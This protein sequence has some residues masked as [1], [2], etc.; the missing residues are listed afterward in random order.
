M[1]WKPM[2][3]VDLRKEF[4]QQSIVSRLSFAELC[5]RYGV[6][7]KTGYKW[8]GRY[9]TRGLQGL[10]DLSKKPHG[11]PV[12]LNPEIEGKIVALKQKRPLWGARKLRKK[13]LERGVPRFLQ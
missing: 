6:S 7:R 1:P 5:S 9:R 4:V 3:T 11:Q 12:H 8:L 10:E 2:N 13:L